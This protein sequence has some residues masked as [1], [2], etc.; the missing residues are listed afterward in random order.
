[1]NINEITEAV[2]DNHI[3]NIIDI[4]GNIKKNK[5]TIIVGDNGTGKSLIRKQMAV[6]LMK[7][8]GDNKTHCRTVSMQLRTE[9][10][11]DWGA[12][13]CMGHD[14]P[15]FPTSL[16]SF[17]LLQSVMNYD[18][19]EKNDYFIILDEIEIGM[20]KESV[21][22][23]A[24]YLNSK[25]PEWLDNTLG[26]IIITH[27]NIIAREIYNN[28]DCDFINIGYNSVDYDINKWINRNIVPTDF[29]FLSEW[30]SRLFHRV[31]ERSKKIN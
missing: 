2:L 20:A 10:R 15:E 18:M 16:S 19:K 8:Y 31:N 14:E 25:I 12:L 26:I 24:N 6:R 22:G 1:M 11:S 23:M 17:N 3:D 7:E 29:D 28:Q 4:I 30:S 27:S 5:V 13:A 21:L 9:L